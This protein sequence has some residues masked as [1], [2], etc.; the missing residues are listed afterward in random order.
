MKNAI[1]PCLAAAALLGLAG[2]DRGPVLASCEEAVNPRLVIDRCFGGEAVAEN[3][4][5][6]IACFPFG[7]PEP[8]TGV[9]RVSKARSV[10][11]S[12]FDEDVPRSD[13]WLETTG[14]PAN[15]RTAARGNAER[16]FAVEF[17]GR[18]SLCPGYFGHDGSL[19]RE[20]VVEQFT[21]ARPLGG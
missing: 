9:W 20:V 15:A 2:C 16:A 10:F 4:I 17:V 6:D 13:M 14:T 12:A 8:M 7:P 19:P 21:S 18:P 3:F 11:R 1:A 5:G